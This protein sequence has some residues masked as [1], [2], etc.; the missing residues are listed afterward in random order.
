[1]ATTRGSS[2]RRLAFTTPPVSQSTACSVC[3]Q[4]H[5]S[6]SSPDY[7]KDEGCRQLVISLDI[8]GHNLV[9][10]PCRNDMAR[11]MKIP[12]IVLGGR[13]IKLVG[14]PFL[15]ADPF[16]SK[17]NIPNSDIVQCLTIAGENI[18][19]KLDIAPPLCKHHYHVVYSVHKP[20][21]TH[22]P[23]CSTGL[24]KDSRPCPDAAS[25]TMYLA[26][27]TGYEGTIGENDSVLFMLQVTLTYTEAHS[28]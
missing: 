3:K 2:R 7:W 24:Q 12:V 23:A 19:S 1:M 6:L 13:R 4:V 26:D 8:S 9:C 21:Q 27:K 22:C 14:V 28:K 16:F 5:T 20:T 25:I 15:S 18:P 10:R 17:C 11:L